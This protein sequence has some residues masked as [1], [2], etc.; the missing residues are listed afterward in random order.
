MT[1]NAIIFLISEIIKNV[2]LLNK[3]YIIII[4]I[5][6]MPLTLF[7]KLLIITFIHKIQIGDKYILYNYNHHT[8]KI[9]NIYIFFLF[10][11]IFI[12]L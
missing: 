5:I 11:I 8:L 12:D 10:F 7:K 3:Q 9:Q 4:V 2:T 6:I 1:L